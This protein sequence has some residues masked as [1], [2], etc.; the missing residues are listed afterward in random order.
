SLRAAVA[1]WLWARPSSCL[2]F[3]PDDIEDLQSDQRL[4]YGSGRPSPL[5]DRVGAVVAALA[6]FAVPDLVSGV[7]GVFENSTDAL[8]GPFSY[9]GI[10]SV[11]LRRRILHRVLAETVRDGAVAESL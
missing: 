9:R 7:L 5:G 4:M 2:A 3:G 8:Q 10:G 6:G 1:G 11:G